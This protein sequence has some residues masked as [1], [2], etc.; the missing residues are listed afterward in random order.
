[1]P[2]WALLSQLQT[3]EERRQKAEAEL[4]V[5]QE[6]SKEAEQLEQ[7]KS[8][9]KELEDIAVAEALR[10]RFEKEKANYFRCHCCRETFKKPEEPRDSFLP[11]M[12][13]LMFSGLLFFVPVIG[14]VLVAFAGTYFLVIILS[15]Q[16]VSPHCP[17]CRSTN[18]SRPEKTDEQK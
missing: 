12:F 1:M 9:A 10:I 17:N 2:E 6:K 3:T 5:K 16:I 4:K 14:G 15:S 8:K 11:S 13:G 18:F 7:K